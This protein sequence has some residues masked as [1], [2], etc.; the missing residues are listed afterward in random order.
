MSNTMKHY[1]KLAASAACFCDPWHC[2][3]STAAA[4]A[5]S[6]WVYDCGPH[7]PEECVGNC[8]IH[9]LVS[10]EA[11]A[12]WILM[13]AGFN[14]VWGSIDVEE[15]EERLA[16]ETPEQTAAR[17]AE[18]A[19]MEAAGKAEIEV[20]R[21][22]KKEEKWCTKGGDM[23]FRVPRPCKYA[24]LFLA[25]TCA[26]CGAK[27]PEGETACRAIKPATATTRQRVCGEVLAGCWNHEQTHTCIYIH[28]DEEHWAAAC[29]G[30]L[31]Y[32]RNASVFYKKGQTTPSA[33][34]L[35]R[36]AGFVATER[37]SGAPSPV[38]RAGAGA[39][40]PPAPVGRAGA[41]ALPPKPLAAAPKAPWA[42]PAPSAPVAKPKAAAAP[43]YKY[44]RLRPGGKFDNS[45]DEAEA[46]AE[47]IE[48]QKDRRGG[49]RHDW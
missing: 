43:V 31:C 5:K 2:E 4:A 12:I 33:A 6:G 40:P 37:A 35:G 11:G 19:R 23:K 30:S 9:P 49:G 45:E 41:G 1:L 48:S 44:G 39:L 27:V 34:G 25:H 24:T 36:F 14:G 32:D 17:L 7:T 46:R 10:G 29:D 16:A 8:R 38:G 21:V 28:P 15:A 13:N 47:W 22:H 20:Y 3:C 18:L 26:G 42:K